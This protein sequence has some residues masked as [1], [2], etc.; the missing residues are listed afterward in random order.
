MVSAN[1]P[2]KRELK[3]P[4]EDKGKITT[5]GFSKCPY[6]EGT[7][8]NL[9]APVNPFHFGFSKCPYE[10]GTESWHEDCIIKE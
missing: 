2:T 6:E 10:E 8:S 3:V 7:E 4:C 5:F 1:V 9:L